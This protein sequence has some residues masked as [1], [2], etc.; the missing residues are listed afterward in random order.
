[1]KATRYLLLIGV[2]LLLLDEGGISTIVG[3]P[4]IKQVALAGQRSEPHSMYQRP[5][6]QWFLRKGQVCD[7]PIPPPA[8]AMPKTQT[9]A[10]AAARITS[11]ASM[12]EL[13]GRPEEICALQNFAV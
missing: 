10:P 2:C 4:S 12:S 6:G 13:G 1:M 8:Y 11:G 3:I 5:D 7:Q 9:Y